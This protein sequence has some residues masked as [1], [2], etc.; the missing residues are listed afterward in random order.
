MLSEDGDGGS[1]GVYPAMQGQFPHYPC[2][3]F[4]STLDSLGCIKPHASNTA[5]SPTTSTR[6]QQQLE[7]T[8]FNL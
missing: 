1:V 4:L 3:H 5:N 6:P 7:F 8:R 2:Y